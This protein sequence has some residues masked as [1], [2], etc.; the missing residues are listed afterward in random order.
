MRLQLLT[1]TEEFHI[2]DCIKDAEEEG[3]KLIYRTSEPHP[4]GGFTF[5]AVM[6]EAHREEG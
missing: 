6:E 4:Y 3:F 1:S 2:N 5:I